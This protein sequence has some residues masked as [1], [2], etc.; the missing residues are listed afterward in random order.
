M[1]S[2]TKLHN[3]V[4]QVESCVTVDVR[5]ELEESDKTTEEISDWNIL[6]CS[7]RRSFSHRAEFSS[8]RSLRSLVICSLF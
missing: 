8:P 1:I 4:Q 6:K 7:R 5:F 2:G 3:V